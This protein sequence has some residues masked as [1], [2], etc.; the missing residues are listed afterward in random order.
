M[1]KFW[2]KSYEICHIYISIL[3]SFVL[4]DYKYEYEFSIKCLLKLESNYTFAHQNI[5][6]K[7]RITDAKEEFCCSFQ[8]PCKR[9]KT[10]EKHNS[11]ER[12]NILFGER[13][14]TSY[15]LQAFILLFFI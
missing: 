8:S 11:G 5:T 13:V 7:N 14:I 1:K 9:I 10:T 3:I 12:L 4:H 2:E 15:L 6:Q